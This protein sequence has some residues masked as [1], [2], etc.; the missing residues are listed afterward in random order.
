[1]SISFYKEICQEGSVK[2]STVGIKRTRKENREKENKEIE[3]CL[4][5]T[6]K[7]CRGTCDK[8]R[9]LYNGK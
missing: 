3:I 6:E 8:I 2:A 9:R 4:N 1:M 7:N 5:C